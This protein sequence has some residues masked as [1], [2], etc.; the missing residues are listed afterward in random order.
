MMDIDKTRQDELLEPPASN[1]DDTFLTLIS[2][3]DHTL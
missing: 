2:C 3:R 1:D